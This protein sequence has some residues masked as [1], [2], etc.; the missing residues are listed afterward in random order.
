MITKS[1]IVAIVAV[2]VGS[3]SAA[4]AND[5]FDVTIYRPAIQDN[6]LGAYAQSPSVDRGRNGGTGPSKLFSAEEKA[7]FDRAQGPAE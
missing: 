1:T 2:L 4:F 3:A 7:M 6:A 5:Q